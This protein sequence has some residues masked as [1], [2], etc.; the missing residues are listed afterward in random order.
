MT[1]LPTAAAPST[2]PEVARALADIEA[3]KDG[4]EL[5]VVECLTAIADLIRQTGDPG[6]VF[7]SVLDAFA[8]EEIRVLAAAYGVRLYA[9]TAEPVTTGYRNE[10]F[11]VWQAD[12]TGIAAIPR[13]QQPRVAL[14]Q[15]RGFIRAR[16]E[17]SR[18]AADFQASVA[19]GYVESL[20]AWHTR[21]ARA[22]K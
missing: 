21:T 20:D 19:A 15:L 9:T 8:R 11:V 5:A 10:T 13:D 14:D 17:E 16:Q 4:A 7:D 3:V 22:A 18:L 1:E 6:T 12:G 2:T